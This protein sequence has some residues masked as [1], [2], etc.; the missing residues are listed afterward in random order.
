MFFVRLMSFSLGLVFAWAVLAKMARP[1]VWLRALDGYRPPEGTRLVVAG[2]VPAAEAAVATLFFAGATRVAAAAT[3]ALTSLF[4]LAI[5]RAR[6]LTGSRLPCGC[7]GSTKERD[8]RAL[9]ARD[10]VLAGAAAALLVYGRD[11]PGYP[12]APVGDGW[13]AASLVVVGASLVV[14][15]FVAVLSGFRRE[16]T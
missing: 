14:W 4:L 13:I 9:I 2:A 15:L 10:A 11:V 8:Y 6:S 16:T 1:G 3:L 5:L 12:Q 7:F